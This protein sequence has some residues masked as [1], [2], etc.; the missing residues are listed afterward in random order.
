MIEE[1]PAMRALLA[2]IVLAFGT[3][4]ALAEPP[5]RSSFQLS[6]AEAL[7]A[8]PA[9]AYDSG[10]DRFLS[11]WHDFRNRATT[12][13]DVYGR[14]VDGR[15]RPVTAD[16]PVANAAGSQGFSAVA[17][18]PL[19]RRYMV[20]WTDWRNV[21]DV[22]SDIYGRLVNADGTLH[23]EEFIVSARRGISQK[24]PNLTYDPVRQRF[25]VLWVDARNEQVDK[26]YGQYL[27]ADG[28][29][30]GEE[31]PVALEG[32]YQDYPS[33]LFD[34]R[35]D[36]FLVVWRDTR[37][38]AIGR[39]EK[40]VYGS[41]ID[42]EQGPSGTSF[43][44]ALEKEGCSP[45]S[46]RAISYAPEEDTYFVAWSSGRNYSEKL[47]SSGGYRDRQRGLDV[48]GAFIS[49]E[50]GS[51]RKQ[52]FAIASEIDYQE[53]PSVSFDPVGNRFLVVWYDLRRPPT[54]RDSDIYGRFVTPKGAMSKEFLISE[55]EAAG[56]RKFP[57]V[58]Y[59]PQSSSFLVLWE[60]GRGRD[61]GRARQIYG[62][63]R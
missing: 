20:V 24:F 35:H 60:D 21:A 32:N 54:G 40:A 18:D 29:P 23:G 15:G 12:S 11:T 25:L 56:T 50:D 47:P 27:D 17:F 61:T 53:V 51:Y 44:I 33:L 38:V 43:R 37:S 55:N 22:D 58:A 52:P 36:R 63:V 6:E 45:L 3:A 49:V 8:R 1:T 13:L 59:S 46:L 9:I 28:G 10:G 2:I 4:S 42:A 16:I 62:A 7:Q 31:F 41:F 19:N 14:I 57:T 34:P 5:S 30:L 39:L 26:L 48:Y